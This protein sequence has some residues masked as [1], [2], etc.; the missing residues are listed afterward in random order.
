MTETTAAFKQQRDTAFDA[1]CAHLDARRPAASLHDVAVNAEKDVWT[2]FLNGFLHLKNGAPD[3]Q[4]GSMAEALA[5]ASLRSS[6]LAA[7]L[8]VKPPQ[9]EPIYFSVLYATGQEA[10]LFLCTRLVEAAEGD[11]PKSRQLL[12]QRILAEKPTAALKEHMA[13]A[14][15]TLTESYPRICSELRTLLKS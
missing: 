9:F 12:Q 5:R 10:A 13:V 4:P 7:T 6:P 2:L 15:A 1:I 8:G 11:F 14:F 3:G